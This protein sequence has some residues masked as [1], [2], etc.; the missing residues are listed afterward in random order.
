MDGLLI[1]DIQRI[2][3]DGMRGTQPRILQTCQYAP[4][5]IQADIGAEAQRKRL[6]IF[7]LLFYRLRIRIHYV[8]YCQPFRNMEERVV[9][10]ER[11]AGAVMAFHGLYCR[12]EVIP[13]GDP[14][15]RS[16]DVG[17]CL[18]QDTGTH[19]NR[20]ASGNSAGQCRNGR[21]KSKDILTRRCSGF[22]QQWLVEL[23]RLSL[24]LSD[25]EFLSG[26]SE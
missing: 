19:H 11:I 2:T 20:A 13:R 8:R 24:L 10:S 12:E 9:V 16:Q 17:R 25:P 5:V 22:G 21:Q 1:L 7:G 18:C 4:A 15:V 3:A 26:C 23:C 6:F 14:R